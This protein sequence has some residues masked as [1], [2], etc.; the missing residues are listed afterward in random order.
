MR[1]LTLAVI[2]LLS[3]QPKAAKVFYRTNYGKVRFHSDAQLESL[4][5]TSTD[6]KGVLELPSRSF[7]FS[8]DVFSFKGFNSPL[9][10]EHFHENYMETKLFPKATFVGKIVEENDFSK[11]GDYTVRAKGVFEIHGIRQERIVK[12]K[13]Q[14]KKGKLTI[15]TS[16]TIQLS[17]FDIL[18]PKVVNLKVSPEVIVDVEAVLEI[19]S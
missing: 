16:L 18:V 8:V 7:A 12:G 4:Q 17:D 11:D 1:L 13:I 15:K 19:K 10:R 14:S 3:W 5:A 2:T 9:Q 6:L